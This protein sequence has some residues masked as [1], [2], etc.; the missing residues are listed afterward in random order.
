MS[1]GEIE[2]AR[3]VL[4]SVRRQ[5]RQAEIAMRDVEQ[6][7]EPDRRLA[8]IWNV[9]VWV[10]SLT[11]ILQRLRGVTD[12]FEPWYARWRDEMKRDPLLRYFYG[13][14]NDVLKE[15]EKPVSMGVHIHHFEAPR[16]VPP[17]PP[18]AVA[19]FLGDEVG[20]NGWEVELPDG[21]RTKIYVSVPSSVAQTT[22]HLVGM[23]TEHLGREI[24]DSAVEG[25]EAYLRYFQ[26][27]IA[28]AEERFG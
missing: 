28:A 5:L 25:C 14:R 3:T 13:L 4:T 21:T 7:D 17:A 1:G 16:D 23:P 15:G 6:N 12:E 24:G 27:M 9:V 26:R 10:R 19:F 22:L 11:P 8:G 2:G 20:G 18:G